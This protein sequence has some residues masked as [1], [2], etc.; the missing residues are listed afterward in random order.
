MTT[1]LT[2]PR[3]EE[4][5]ALARFMH[6][7]FAG[8]VDGCLEW[9]QSH[10]LA[11]L[12]VLRDASGAPASAL[13][14]IP[15]AQFFGGSAP[16]TRAVPMVG[17]AGVAVPPERRG[18]GLGLEMMRACVRELAERRV[19]LSGLYASTKALYH[20]VGYGLAGHRVEI[21]APL[22]QLGVRERGAPIEPLGES[23]EPAV[24]ECYA[25]FARATNGMLDRPDYIWNRTRDYRDLT[26]TGFGVRDGA[27]TLEGYVFLA[28][29]PNPARGKHE[30]AISDLVFTTPRAGRRLLGFL[31]DFAMMASTM[32]LFGSPSHPLLA[33]VPQQIFTLT[34]RE[35]WMTRITHLRSALTERG[36]PS[37]VSGRLTLEVEDDLIE[38]HRGAWDVRVSHGAADID[39]GAGPG[40]V[41]RLHIRDLASLYTG[42]FTP[43]QA[44]L[45]GLIDAGDEACETLGAMFA[46]GTPAMT[47]FF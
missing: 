11:N 28:Q 5:P 34:T 13:A 16:G 25:R 3:A 46:G 18:L 15:M 19:A 6:Y 39:R 38:A 1:T 2:Q 29:P 23:A 42:L 27:G 8:P 21:K 10:T 26:Y 31:A 24:R 45:A 43:A 47:D 12:R 17:I 32:T 9:L 14:Q 30:V 41:A 4:L 40:P 20:Q 44:R 22:D 7:A 33:L 35:L 37:A 36:Y